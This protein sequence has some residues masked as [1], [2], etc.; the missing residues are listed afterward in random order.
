M[1]GG[2]HINTLIEAWNSLPNSEKGNYS[3]LRSLS[4][5]HKDRTYKDQ[6]QT[7]MKISRK[8]HLNSLTM[9]RIQ[10]PDESI[11]TPDIFGVVSK[12]DL[13]SFPQCE[14]LIN[15]I[16][17]SDIQSAN[18]MGLLRSNQINAVLTLGNNKPL[19][20]PSVRGGY[21]CIA[22]EDNERADLLKLMPDI[23]CFIDKQLDN[24]NILIH[25]L[26]GKNR[27]CAVAIGYLMKKFFMKFEEAF[28]LIEKSR[29]SCEITDN[30]KKQ[31]NSRRWRDMCC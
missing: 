8:K 30:F 19:T 25:C 15:S 24:G 20:Y 14:D 23:Y 27:S 4:L 5:K 18:D 13:S 7:H 12:I 1:K 28:D 9:I 17:I 22:L 29:P 31:L 2:N 16:Y 10:N 3:I 6:T 21:R 26:R 11:N